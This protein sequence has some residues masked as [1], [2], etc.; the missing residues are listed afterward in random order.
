MNA[1]IREYLANNYPDSY[2]FDN[3]DEAIIGIS[4]TGAVIYE[5]DKIIHILMGY[6][7]NMTYEEAVEYFDYN[8]ERTLPY[9]NEGIAPVIMKNI[10]I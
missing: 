2:L 7:D 9:M 1:K 3:F 8:I 6:L 5:F 10:E 4:T